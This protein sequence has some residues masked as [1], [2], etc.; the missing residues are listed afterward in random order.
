MAQRQAGWPGS[1]QGLPSGWS[2]FSSTSPPR[3]QVCQGRRE[4]WAASLLVCVVGVV[5]VY[6]LVFGLMIVVLLPRGG[7]TWG[8]V[9][10]HFVLLPTGAGSPAARHWQ[11]E[12]MALLLRGES[13]TGGACLDGWGVDMW[14]IEIYIL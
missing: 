2:L 3:D 8:L 9:C 13:L 12:G 14:H 6:F 11:W 1:P 4:A 5:C 10:S 7:S